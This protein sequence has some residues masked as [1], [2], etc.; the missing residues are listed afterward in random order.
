MVFSCVAQESSHLPLGVDGGLRTLV[1]DVE[2]ARS[3]PGGSVVLKAPDAAAGGVLHGRLME[4]GRAL[5][6]RLLA[7]D[8]GVALAQEVGR[9]QASRR[10][11]WPDHRWRCIGEPTGWRRCRPGR[12]PPRRWAA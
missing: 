4:L 1:W 7:G 3:R 8:A 11:S 2:R 5:G 10:C 9:S 12:K 6:A